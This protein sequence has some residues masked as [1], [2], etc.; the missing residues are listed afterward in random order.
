MAVRISM[1][2]LSAEKKTRTVM[3]KL[4]QSHMKISCSLVVLNALKSDK[5]IIRYTVYLYRA[6][7]WVINYYTDTQYLKPK[8]VDPV[9][10]ALRQQLENIDISFQLHIVHWNCDK[11]SSFAEAADKPDGLCVLGVFLQ[12][13]MR[14][15]TVS[16]SLKLTLAPFLYPYIYVLAKR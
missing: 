1:R 8:S 11:Y 13:T 15:Y 9:I 10:I 6:K 3:Q 14:V 12:V 5:K 4:R 16:C 2:H 7:N